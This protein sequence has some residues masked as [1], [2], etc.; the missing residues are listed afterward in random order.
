MH[1]HLNVKFGKYF[2]KFRQCKYGDKNKIRNVS[3]LGRSAEEVGGFKRAG[4][5]CVKST[6]QRVCLCLC[7][8]KICFTFFDHSFCDGTLNVTALAGASVGYCG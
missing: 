6:W 2:F 8:C 3:R 1:G 7:F 5:S 4:K